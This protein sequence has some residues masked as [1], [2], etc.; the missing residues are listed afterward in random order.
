MLPP[1]ISTPVAPW[2]FIPAPDIYML[3]PDFQGWI[4]RSVPTS[5]RRL[6]FKRAPS[7]LLH[8]NCNYLIYAYNYWYI[9]IYMHILVQC[10]YCHSS[11]PP[12][13]L[14]LNC[15]YPTY[16]ILYCCWG[17]LSRVPRALPVYKISV[18]LNA[19]T[20]YLTILGVYFRSFRCKIWNL[21][22]LSV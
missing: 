21:K 11:W 10:H 12:S 2:I 16:Y 13:L 15:N 9:Y 14:H 5:G 8:L 18:R 20:K 22:I 19:K 3:P 4:R 7:S 1:D 17:P 6:A